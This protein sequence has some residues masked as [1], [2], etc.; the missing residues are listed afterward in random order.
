MATEADVLLIKKLN[1]AM[2]SGENNLLFNFLQNSRAFAKLRL[3]IANGNIL[4][5]FSGHITP[6][7]TDSILI[8][9]EAIF[10]SEAF[11]EDQ[12][13]KSPL[14]ELGQPAEGDVNSTLSYNAY[15]KFVLPLLR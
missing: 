13:N 1:S 12:D 2:E 14:A 4:K 3:G 9:S 15:L 7:L 6:S 5:L 11:M 8:L 10:Q